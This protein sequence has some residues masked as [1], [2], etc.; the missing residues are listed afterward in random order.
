MEKEK[1]KKHSIYECVSFMFNVAWS[2]VKSVI[3]R[4]I[5]LAL[6]TVILQVCQLYTTPIILAKVENSAPINELLVTI[7]VITVVLLVIN[8][9]LAYQKENVLYGRIEVRT[10]IVN[11]INPKMLYNFLS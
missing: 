3:F 5:L 1:K 8:A 6:T 4:C 11:L 7:L 10:N 9:L 2:K